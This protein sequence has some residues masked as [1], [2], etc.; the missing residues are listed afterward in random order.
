MAHRVG[1]AERAAREGG[2]RVLREY[3]RR[4]AP[5]RGLPDFAVIGAKRGG[6]T[7]LYNYLLEHPS[8]APMFPARQNIKGTHYFDSHYWRGI[9]WYKSHFPVR[10]GAPGSTRL[11]G[12]GSPYY[13]FHPLAASRMAADTPT[14]RLVVLLRDPVE[15]AYSHYKERVRHQAESLSF[16]DAIAREPERL[17]G[18]EERIISTPGY[19]SREHEDHSYVAQGI[20]APMLR[21]WFDVFDPQRVLVLF[22]ED[23]YA[24]PDKTANQV[25]GFLGLP[26]HDLKDRRRFNYHDAPDL[27]QETRSALQSLLAEHNAELEDLLKRP[28]PW[29]GAAASG[30]GRPG[31]DGSAPAAREQPSDGGRRSRPPE[32][33]SFPEQWPS[34]TVVVPTRDR[35]ELLQ[36]AVRGILEQDYKGEIVCVVVFDR[37]E[38]RSVDADVG[39]GRVLRLV[40]NT[41]SPGLAGARNSGY[42][43]ATSPLIANCDDDDV[44]H[45][46]KL[47]R[48]VEAMVATGAEL[49]TTGIEI[50]VGD[51]L[52]RRLPPPLVDFGRLLRERATGVHPSTYLVRRQALFDGIGLVD[53]RLPGSYGEDY[54]WLLRASWR[55]PVVSV[56]DPLVTVRWS[57][58]S[59]FSQDWSTISSALSYLLER[60]PEL[61]LSRTG[62]ARLRGQISFA[63]AAG[64]ER[65]TALRTAGSA[66]RCNPL[67]KR[68]YLAVAVASGLLRPE[69][70]IKVAN[71]TGH[72]I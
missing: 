33:A 16:E 51:R 65:R 52:V 60:H 43:L 41:R 1:A 5:S 34:V 64:G 66:L 30:K 4:T 32:A 38:P 40:R 13:L 18:E 3:G 23:F 71:R 53:E 63:E 35:P 46:E 69:W 6:T 9:D 19:L 27:A 10:R 39:D 44:W 12:E 42:D 21:R 36:R 8:V 54:E 29:S 56:S 59:Y 7:S 67:E 72:G 50:E 15:R 25:W 57:A 14:T 17:R 22:S 11:T 47:S 58:R 49:V 24:D 45:R 55:R 26:P 61:Q 48:Q 70:V 62:L 28:L 37:S 68:A 20:Y 31:R 2:K